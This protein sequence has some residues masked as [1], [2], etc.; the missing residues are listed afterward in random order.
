MRQTSDVSLTRFPTYEDYLRARY[1]VRG[2]RLT[3]TLTLRSGRLAYEDIDLFTLAEQQGTPLTV[4]HTPVIARRIREMVA[5]FEQARQA[6]GYGGEFIYAY[7]SKAS[8][9]EEVVRTALSAGAHYETSSSFD[10][11]IAHT[12]WRAGVLPPARFIFCNGFKEAPYARNIRYLREAGYARI[13]PVLDTP[14]ELQYYRDVEVPMLVGLRKRTEHAIATVGSDEIETRFGM[15]MPDLMAT[16][17][18]IAQTPS[19]T[20]MLFHA[21]VGSQLEDEQRFAAA[22]LEEVEHYCV[23]ARRFPSLRYFDFGGGMPTRYSLDFTF[24]YDRFARVLLAGIKQVC[25]AR[26]V[27]EPHIIGEF[28]R[29]TCNDYGLHIFRVEYK[30]PVKHGAG[31][32]YILNGSLMVSLPDAWKLGQTFIVLPANAYD[33]PPVRVWLA[34]ARTCDNDDVYGERGEAGGQPRQLILPDLPA[35]EDL[36]IVFAATGAYQ[37]MLSAERGGHHCL[38]PTPKEVVFDLAGGEPL[39]TVSPGQTCA[40]IMDRLG[41]GRY[42]KYIFDDLPHL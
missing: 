35:G 3:D 18:R 28:G 12:L 29:Y 1:G 31:F 19:L 4:K 33:R 16:A 32:W 37:S 34:G 2:S 25:H 8:A 40:A 38:S 9:N 10:V 13:V 23:L 39:A 15:D 6:T 30:K 41:Y 21:M 24:D 17:E 27:P 42:R 5:C 22:L 11:D 36:Y 20:L 14:E 7:A 26:G